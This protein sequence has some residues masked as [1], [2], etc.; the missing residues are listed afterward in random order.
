LSADGSLLVTASDNTTALVWDLTGRLIATKK[1]LTAKELEAHWH[2]LA[3]DDAVGG[4]QAVRTLAAGPEQ[5]VAFL[6]KQLRPAPDAKRI[7]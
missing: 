5:A 3:S 2:D 7:G 4:Q 1:P 6:T